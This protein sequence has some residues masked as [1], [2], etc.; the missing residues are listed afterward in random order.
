MWSEQESLQVDENESDGW[1]TR[2]SL[3][4]MQRACWVPPMVTVSFWASTVAVMP[5]RPRLVMDAA[6]EVAIAARAEPFAAGVKAPYVAV[7]PSVFQLV[8]MPYWSAACPVK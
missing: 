4:I 3:V 6:T 2:R 7:L 1:P 5:A 8:Y